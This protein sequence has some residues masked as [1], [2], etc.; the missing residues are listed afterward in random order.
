MPIMV[1]AAGL[2]HAAV[3]PFALPPPRGAVAPAAVRAPAGAAPR[4]VLA[5]DAGRGLRVDVVTL[6][7]ALMPYDEVL[8]AVRRGLDIPVMLVRG[9][10]VGSGQMA[11]DS[12]CAG[13]G[14]RNAH[15][16]R[17][18][19]SEALSQVGGSSVGQAQKKLPEFTCSHALADKW[20]T[21][22]GFLFVTIS[23]RFLARGDVGQQGWVCGQAEPLLA[24]HFVP[25]SS[26]PA[27]VRM[28]G[29]SLG[30]GRLNL[31]RS[32]AAGASTAPA[33]WIA[34]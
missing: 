26:G 7:R 2:A 23:T 1:R 25:F 21:R 6:I 22:G 32:A 30:T 12:L 27:A 33:K 29:L 24:A 5:P 20:A 31:G 14:P 3:R 17:P 4:A 34:D 13:A 9:S 15:C 10:S 8:D 28:G 19:E 11:V 16:P 18:T